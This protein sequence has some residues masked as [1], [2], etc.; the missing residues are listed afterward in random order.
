[1]SES[2][3]LDYELTESDVA[4]G[5][6]LLV[7]PDP[8]SMSWRPTLLR[9][10]WILLALSGLLMVKM[11]A[12]VWVR[13]LRRGIPFRVLPPGSR[14]ALIGI[15]VAW[16]ILL[17]AAATLARDPDGALRWLR[18]RLTRKLLSGRAPGSRTLRFSP[19]GLEVEVETQTSFRAWTSVRRAV[20][21]ERHLVLDARDLWFIVPLHALAADRR[22]ALINEVAARLPISV[23]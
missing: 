11:E 7:R 22:A 13:L 10:V 21:S 2:L 1:M 9:V 23:A 20:R 5:V 18:A 8:R 15:P 19:G 6:E 14:I 3:R 12:D 17:L 16:T 4:A